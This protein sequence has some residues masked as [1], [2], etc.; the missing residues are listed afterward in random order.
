MR[1]NENWDRLCEAAIAYANSESE[2][3]FAAAKEALV[4]AAAT[5]AQGMPFKRKIKPRS[6]SA[7]GCSRPRRTSK[8]ELCS[9]HYFRKVKGY[10]M[11]APK[12]MA[13]KVT[14]APRAA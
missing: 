13:A 11:N 1:N 8:C 14:P 5:Y 4:D 3:E 9:F 7:L 10:S 12:H 2:E 6:C